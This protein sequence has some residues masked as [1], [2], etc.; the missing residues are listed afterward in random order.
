MRIVFLGLS[1]SSTW[2]NGHATTYRAL[3]R[4]LHMR[5]HHLVFLE[6]NV[7][8]YARNRDLT[9]PDFCRL[10]LYN[11]LS[12]LFHR[13]ET[14]IKYADL[15]IVGSYVPEG[16]AVSNWVTGKSGGITAFYDIDTP[17]T[18]NKLANKD[19]EYISPDQIQK[20]HLY[21]SF[22]GGALLERLKA[23]FGA[24]LI[25]PLY[26]SADPDIYYPVNMKTEWDLG[27]MG[28]YS[29]ER[30]D[31]VERFFLIPARKC[32]FRRFA[33]AG[34]Q[35]PDHIDWPDNVLRIPHLPCAEHRSFYNQQRFTLNL[36]RDPMVKAGYSPS[37]RIFE[38]AACG[39]TILSDAW[40]GIET[41]FQPGS[42]IIILRNS[43]EVCD[44]LNSMSDRDRKAIG[45]AARARYLREHTPAKRACE[46]EVYFKEALSGAA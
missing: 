39:S 29:A 33:I 28:T 10:E 9:A 7:E 40:A 44:M 21:L 17:V 6:R 3:M 22:T 14:D 16:V 34:A 46:L 32:R 43:L 11:D 31:A 5:G 25:K 19:F 36:T 4:A 8:W 27:Y 18:L 23:D 42:E 2:G 20:F 13:F 12:D 45:Q 35:F 26:C 15:V 41:F 24:Q 1:L 38:A 37:V 30:Q